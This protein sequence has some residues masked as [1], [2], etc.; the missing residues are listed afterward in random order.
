VILEW[1]RT[2]TG[3][4]S[5]SFGTALNTGKV[6]LDVSP[7]WRKQYVQPGTRIVVRR[8]VLRMRD[9]VHGAQT[10]TLHRERVVPER[11]TRS[12]R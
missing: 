11:P 2:E 5:P 3:K 10:S 7:D 9:A 1:R 12:T 6:I 8:S 4:G